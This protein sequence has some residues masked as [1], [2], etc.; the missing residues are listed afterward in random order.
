[1]SK[2]SEIAD[3]KYLIKQLPTATA[4]VNT[5]FELVYA[6][7]KWLTQHNQSPCDAFG[8]RIDYL[9]HTNNQLVNTLSNCINDKVDRTFEECKYDPSGKKW[10]EWHCNPWLDS[11]ENV[12]GLIIRTE[13]VTQLKLSEI[14]L[15]R[16]RSKL[17]IISEIGKIGSWEYD[18]IADKVIWCGVTRKIHEVDS[19]FEPSLEEGVAFY[20][21]GYS[22]N[23]ISMAV[24]DA[25]TKGKSYSEKLQIITAKGNEIWVQANGT[26]VYEDNKIV[27]LRGTF[28]DINDKVKSEHK[29]K[30]N[31]TLLRTLIDNLPLNIYIKDKESRKILVNKAEC[32]YLGISDANEILGK[33]NFELYD[34]DI[35][36]ALNQE[37]QQVM[38][39]LVPI[40][41]KES[42][43]RNKNG[44]TTTFLISKIPLKDEFGKANGIV[45][46]SHDI[47]RLKQ[48]E[49]KLKDLVNV[50]SLQNKKLVNFAHIVSHNLRSHTANFSMLLE[51]LVDEKDEE[52]KQNIIGMLTNAS[53]NLME[54]LENLNEVVAINTNVGLEKKPIVLREKIEVVEQNLSAFLQGHN[55]TIIN[56]VPLDAIIKVVPA[57][58]ESIL[59]NFITNAVKYSDPKRPPLVKLSCRK[60]AGATILSIEDNGLGIDLK[61]Y[62]DKLFG[63]YKTFHNHKDSRG[64]G[65]Y[66]TK[67]QIESMNGRVVVCSEVGTGTTFNIYFNEED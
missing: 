55:A 36:E 17:D 14:N 31:E 35:A 15:G 32:D 34:K 22:K 52:E 62:G 16:L 41:N 19:E 37:D 48:N 50:A 38:D 44:E 5:D 2:G 3:H 60:T 10:F 57:Y 61:K 12:I 58:I 8:K 54:T 40:L 63:M 30:A 65:L 29:T 18:L 7:D 59:M 64:I 47:T 13:D 51:F 21:E 24:H 25:L 53:N 4:F 27:A 23:L 28:Q 66:I 9:Y 67:N 45:G 20:K 49:A 42:R 26:P 11:K 46:I 33:N 1:M 56:N 43:I 39:T 6:S